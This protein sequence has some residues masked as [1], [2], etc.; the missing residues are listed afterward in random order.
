MSHVSPQAALAQVGNYFE[1]GCS[2]LTAL[3]LNKPFKQAK[4]YTK[5]GSVGN[6]GSYSGLTPGDLVG[7]ADSSGLISHVAVYVGSYGSGKQFVDV[8]GPQKNCRQLNSYG[9]DKVYRVSY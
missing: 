1:Q 6:N 2:G 9:A 7:L 4:Y 8:P 5:G 3:L